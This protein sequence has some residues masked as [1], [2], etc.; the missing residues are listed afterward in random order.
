M[1]IDIVTVLVVLSAAWIGFQKGLLQPLLTEVFALGTLLL[2]LRNRSGFLS[3]TEVLF[4]ANVILAVIMAVV[5]ALVMGYLGSRAGAA[6]HKMPVIR[7]VDGFLGVWLQ[8]LIG[9]AF[10]YLLISG[11]IA[12]GQ[13]FNPIKTPTVSAAQLQSIE[14]ALESNPFTASIV[15]VD[16]L[17]AFQARAAQAGV[18]IGDVP[19]V[20][21]MQSLYRDLL[22]PQLTG[23]RLAPFVMSV[24]SHIPW[25]GHFG[26][27]D[28]PGRS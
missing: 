2:I 14:R 22:L 18:R 27:K 21:Q 9:L 5:L 4:H 1:I 17:R 12:M 7:G 10:C 23:S 13:A 19:G 24:G 8:A 20:G 6:I 25:L 28:L 15:D 26:P 3:L 16:E 11:I